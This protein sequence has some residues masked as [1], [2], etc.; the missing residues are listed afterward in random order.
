MHYKFFINVHDIKYLF[1]LLNK[2]YNS[3]NSVCIIL[4]HNFDIIIH[5]ILFSLFFF[6]IMIKLNNNDNK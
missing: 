5:R 3:F 1:F 6:I 4:I 2:N